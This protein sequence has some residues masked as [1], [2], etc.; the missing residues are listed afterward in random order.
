[1]SEKRKFSRVHF[2]GQCFLSEIINNEVV[3]WQS[4]LLDI[5]L[6]GALVKAID[7]FT[8]NVDKAIKLNLNLEGSDVTL[9]ISGVLCH[10]ENGFIGIK[11]VTLDIES[12]THLKRL[13]QLNVADSAIMDREISQLINP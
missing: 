3:Q 11:F 10:Q 7:D 6:K 1:M 12:I 8:Y 9:E 4:E 13:I 5:S 2:T